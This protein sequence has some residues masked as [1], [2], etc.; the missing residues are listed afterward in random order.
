MSTKYTKSYFESLSLNQLNLIDIN[1]INILDR[2]YFRYIKKKKQSEMTYD[3]LQKN[4]NKMILNLEISELGKIQSIYNDVDV[5]K[6]IL[7]DDDTFKSREQISLDKNR[8]DALK[9]WLSDILVDSKKVGYNYMMEKFLCEVIEK[10]IDEIKIE[11]LSKYKEVL[12]RKY[13]I[14]L[15]F[16]INRYKKVSNYTG[17]FDINYDDY[18]HTD[19]SYTYKKT[20]LDCNLKSIE[21]L[22]FK[23][24][25]DNMLKTRHTNL[26]KKINGTTTLVETAQDESN[27]LDSFNPIEGGETTLYYLRLVFKGK[28]YYKI[29]V[30]INDVTS[31]YNFKDFRVIDKILYEKKLTHA[32]TIEK[33][34][35]KEFNEHIFP[36]GILS[37]GATEIFD[38]DVLKMDII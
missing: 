20:L 34:I 14:I 7:T 19:I 30:T 21:A 8:K 29:G 17:Y 11:R 27:V 10:Y 36:L 9:K 22:S 12:K 24:D 25:I 16:L 26:M 32:N 6:L 35:L 28:N 23:K 13:F 5:I 4:K 33:A 1:E 38:V 18:Y 37:S 31:R 15:I 3:T 2:T